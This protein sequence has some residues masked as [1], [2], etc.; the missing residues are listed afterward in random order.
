MKKLDRNLKVSLLALA[1]L[2]VV[3][4]VP[5]QAATLT[6]DPTAA[7]A[8]AAGDGKCSLREAVLSVNAGADTGDCVAVVATD[9]Y[10]TNDTITMPAGTYTLTK[11]GLDESYTDAAPSDPGTVPVVSNTPDA[12]IGDLDIQK[13]VKIIGAGAATTTIQWDTAQP[14]LDRIFHAY[15][16][17]G[18]INLDIQGVTLT[19][20]VTREVVIK[21]G[22]PT[23]VSGGLLATTYYLRRAGGAVAVGPAASVVLIDP[24]LT[25][26]ANSE[27]RGGSQKP[28]APSPGGA[29][30]TLA[31]TNVIVDGNSAQGDGGGVYTGSAMTATNVIVRNNVGSTNGGGIYNEG[32]TNIVGSTISG[33][34]SEGGG[35]FFGTGSNTVN[36]TGTTLSGNTAVGGGA[37][38]G[39]AGV[40]M[41]IVN[42]TISGNIGSD[43]GAGLYTNGSAHLNFV[44]I[45]KNLAGADSPNAGSGINTFPATSSGSTVTL[46]NVLLEGNKKGWLAGMDA[47]AIAALLSGNCGK[48]GSG[49]PV[50]SQGSNLSSDASCDTWLTAT[51]DKKSVDPKIDVL[52]LNGNTL[53]GTWTHA[54]LAGSPALAAGTA[55]ATVTVDQRGVTRDAVPDIGAYELSASVT[56][57]SGGSS[58][59][60]TLNPNASFEPGL[61]ALLGAAIGALFLRR[62][63]Q[64]T[65]NR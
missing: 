24:N 46:K 7:D 19:K 50:T 8:S 25:G 5:A 13:S 27:G 2:A 49:L 20:G 41:N 30:Y 34:T 63:R 32:N 26:Q 38:S 17:T 10:G 31:L 64:L 37:I 54:L 29:T 51:N 59:G 65:E 58:S 55:D 42:S 4:G 40:T 35:G 6:V 9:A 36:I 47:T 53:T 12:T 45:A 18:T 3:A 39:R 33:N 61:L 15:A 52:A 57:S 44:T 16:A 21:L 14:T 56:P 48:T 22:P 11:Y 23:T 28:G 62:R 60:C 43:V 1:V